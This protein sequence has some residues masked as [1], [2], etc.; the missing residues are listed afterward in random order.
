MDQSE[1]IR[2]RVSVT[3]SP[4][5]LIRGWGTRGYAPPTFDLSLKLF[6]LGTKIK[7]KSKGFMNKLF[8]KV[9]NKNK[10]QKV[11]VSFLL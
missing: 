3:I 7:N 4:G 5:A 1:G 6:N 2:C 10:R 11:T 8:D 9:L